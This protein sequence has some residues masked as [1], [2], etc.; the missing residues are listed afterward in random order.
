MTSSHTLP[1]LLLHAVCLEQTMPHCRRCAPDI[2]TIA[3][4]EVSV[5]K[6]PVINSRLHI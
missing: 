5:K 3:K 4:Q 1:T 6:C 2:A